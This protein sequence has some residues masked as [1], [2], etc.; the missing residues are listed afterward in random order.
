M[1]A[2]AS[3]SSSSSSAVS[4]SSAAAAANGSAQPATVGMSVTIQQENGK[5]DVDCQLTDTVAS[6]RANSFGAAATHA[7]SSAKCT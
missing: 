5:V 7:P 4:S 6:V 3:S 2:K 1:A